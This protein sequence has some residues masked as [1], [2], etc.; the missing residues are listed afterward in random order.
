MVLLS[1]SSKRYLLTSDHGE[2]WGLAAV[3][4]AAEAAQWGEGKI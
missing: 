1:S 4:L 3:E 2:D